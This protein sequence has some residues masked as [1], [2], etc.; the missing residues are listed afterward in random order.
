MNTRVFTYAG[1]AAGCLLASTEG[2]AEAQVACN[3]LPSPQ[4][5]IQSGD[6]QEPL[7]KA[8]GQK[9][10]NSTMM[11]MTILYNLTGTC[12]ITGNLIAGTKLTVNPNYIPSSTEMPSWDPTQPS[13]TCT[14]DTVAGVPID[15]G[16]AAT[17]PESCNLGAFPAPLGEIRGPV[18]AYG[19]VV[20][21]AS[22]QQAIIAEEGYFV[23]GFGK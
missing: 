19:F 12:T 21:K 6:T 7:L 4:I 23:F 22:D 16:I 10:R 14:I 3:T 20:P 18:Q 2:S 8:L 5:V 11:P 13:P 9:L 17:F 1:L 15:V